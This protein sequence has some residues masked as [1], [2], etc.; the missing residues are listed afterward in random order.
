MISPVTAST[1]LAVWVVVSVVRVMLPTMSSV[2][3]TVSVR[4]L[5]AVRVASATASLVVLVDVT[6]PSSRVCTRLKFC[7]CPSTTCVQVSVMVWAVSFVVPFSCL[8]VPS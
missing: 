7:S 6:T 8:V 5:V 2:P 1:A 4:V 3:L